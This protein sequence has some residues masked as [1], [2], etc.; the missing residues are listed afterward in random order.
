[1]QNPFRRN[2]VRRA[3][4]DF[5]HSLE[6][7]LLDPN[8][9]V[10]GLFAR[11]ARSEAKNFF[12]LHFDTEIEKFDRVLADRLAQALANLGS[13]APAPSSQLDREIR[14]AL[15]VL[16]RDHRKALFALPA[17]QVCFNSACATGEPVPHML[18]ERDHRTY[19]EVLAEERR[20]LPTCTPTAPC[21]L[22]GHNGVVD[23]REAADQMNICPKALIIPDKDSK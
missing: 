3:L 20:M 4:T 16:E 17:D 8:S 15:T 21:N 9:E 22:P 12:G 5:V 1:M 2:S 6:Q 19:G 11:V 18:D 10:R 14:R 7:D 23:P 13:A